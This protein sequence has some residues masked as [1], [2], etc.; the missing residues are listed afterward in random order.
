MIKDLT[1][2]V[3][4]SGTSAGVPAI[5]CSCDVCTSDDP[6]NTRLRTA[7]AICWEDPD[8]VDR[9]LLID[10]GPDLRQQ[11][12][13]AGID[14]CDG[15][16]V[17]H[18]HVDHVF[19]LDELRRF[20]AVQKARLDVW[21]EARV[22]THLRRVFGHIFEPESNI[23]PSFV[24]RLDLQPLEPGVPIERWGLKITP[25]RL[26]HG[27][28]PILGFRFEA[29]DGRSE[30]P[31]P[32]AWCTDVSSVPDVSMDALSGLRTLFL[33]MLRERPHETH[34]HLDAAT[35]LAEHIGAGQTWFVHMG[36]EVDHAT[37]EADLPSGMGLA[38]DGLICSS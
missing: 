1:C 10:A 32:L 18:N 5:G 7:A 17:T 4:G 16:L 8:G 31:L 19:G 24:A 29:A 25:I 23:N 6:R 30:G 38:W 22:Q 2:T 27:A 26:M 34:L 28:L 9:V 12:L 35:A 13:R 37:V 15:V 33:D 11:V 3:L 14:R 36:H 20:N 21:A